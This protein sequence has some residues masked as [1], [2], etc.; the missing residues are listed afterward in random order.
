[1]YKRVLRLL[2]VLVL[3][4]SI[5]VQVGAEQEWPTPSGWVND[6]AHVLTPTEI[7]NMESVIN[8]MSR[9]SGVEVTVVTIPSTGSYSPKEYAVELFSRWGVGKKGADNGLLI[10]LAVGERRIEVE[11]G[12]GLE[13]TLPDGRVGA[14][15]DRFFVPE[16]K[17]GRYGAGILALLSHLESAIVATE[18]LPTEGKEGGDLLFVWITI[19][20]LASI[21]G[22][23]LAIIRFSKGTKAKCPRCGSRLSM[24]RTLLTEPTE[25]SDG[26][27]RV[28]YTC[29][30]CG[31]HRITEIVLPALATQE[32]IRMG[33]GNWPGPGGFWGGSGGMRGGGGSGGFGGFGGGRSGGGGA[34]RGW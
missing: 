11:T 5:G 13:G 8:R 15:L 6:Y 28:T 23:I 27:Q 1:M 25:K 22:S 17:M 16:A 29:A 20:V 34:G 18:G 7:A 30:K 4:I 9:D 21:I 31:Y 3:L 26:A 32:A 10:L 33:R 2:I 24:E 19:L 12:Y 14:L